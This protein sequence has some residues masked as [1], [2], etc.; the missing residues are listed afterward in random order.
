MVGAFTLLA[1][2]LAAGKEVVVAGQFGTSDQVDA[3]ALALTIP[4]FAISLFGGALNS[5]LI[6]SYVDVRRREGAESAQRL[7]SSVLLMALAL[8]TA[9]GLVLAA[10]TPAL[11][12]FV[13][14]RFSPEKLRLTE[15]LSYLLMP[16]VVL[17]GLGMALTAVLNAHERFAASSSAGL[18]LP[19]VSIAAL[20]ALTAVIGIYALPV[21][22]LFGYL[23]QLLL[24]VRSVHREGLR[25]LPS[26]GGATPA[27]RKL[28]GQYA[29]MLAGGLVMGTNPVID[30]MMAARLDA[31]SVASLSYG[32]KLVAFAMGIGALSLSAAVF[33]HFSRLASARDWTGLGKTLR[34]YALAVLAVTIPVTLGAMLLSRPIAGLLYERGAFSHA[35]TIK[36]G[37]IQALYMAQV[38]FHLTGLLFVR[39]L[40]AS[41]GNRMLMWMSGVSAAVNVTGNILFSRWLGAPGIA[42]ST[43]VVYFTS[44][45][46]LGLSAWRRLCAL[47]RSEPSRTGAPLR[48]AG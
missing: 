43:A 25:V 35:D 22:L 8:L 37:H 6:P 9:A 28:A 44:F 46:L 33:P 18:A 21:G 3:F 48:Q 5:A 41:A 31:G 39:F 2:V 17:A 40:S 14:G 42:L 29:P 34:T 27:F 36:V 30:S 1:K 45:T 23:A 16:A 38:P 4:A 32:N 26:W 11:L 47:R 15:H 24:L 7:F 20:L 13:A 10:L 12:S 19:V